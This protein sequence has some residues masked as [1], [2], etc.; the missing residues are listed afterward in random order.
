LRRRVS[1]R[2]L[3]L[4]GGNAN[5]GEFLPVAIDPA[6]EP[7]TKSTGV[8]LVGLAFA[9]ERNGSDEKTL[10]TRLDQPAMK[11]ETKAAGFGHGIDGQPFNHPL[12][13]LAEELIGGEFARGL[14]SGMI[15]LH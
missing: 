9:I 3:L 6:G 4:E 2:A 13:H 14:Q 8:E 5:G 11:H 15:A 7:P 1:S 10:G 12:V